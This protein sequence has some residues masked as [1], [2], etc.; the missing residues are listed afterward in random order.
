M[1]G[2]E[3]HDIANPQYLFQ[4]VQDIFFKVVDLIQDSDGL[5]TGAQCVYKF[6]SEL[7]I[8]RF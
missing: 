1:Q 7:Y 5:T 4:F 8:S 6:C 3:T 2:R